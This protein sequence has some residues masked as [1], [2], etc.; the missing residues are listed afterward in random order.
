[1]YFLLKSEVESIDI[2]RNYLIKR[3]FCPFCRK[4]QLK[5]IDSNDLYNKYQCWNKNCDEKGAPFVVMNDYI[6]NEDLFD[7]TCNDCQER[8]HREFLIDDSQNLLLYFKCDGKLCETNLEPY[9]YNFSIGEWNGKSPKFVSYDDSL[10]ANDLIAKIV[11]KNTK[12]F[13]SFESE[14][15]DAFSQLQEDFQGHDK[16]L[17]THCIEDIPLLTMNNHEYSEFLMYHQNKVVVLVD[18]PNFIRTLRRLFPRQFNDILK[19]AHKMLIQYVQKSFHLTS[20]Y[21][22]RYFSKPD[23]DLQIPNKILMDFC[24]EYPEQEFFHLLKVPKRGGYSDIDNYLIAN[25]VEIL[26]RCDIK[27]FVIVSSDKDYLPVMRIASYKKVKSRILGI[28]TPEIY[29]KYEIEDVKF[30]GM[31]RFFEN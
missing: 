20:D 22:I 18:T 6:Q 17:Q 23:K 5:K 27:G 26:E 9:C 14:K 4:N 15:E 11:K 29:E 10:E 1:M 7:D 3:I 13:H 12:T 2:Q 21:I 30:L 24:I 31:M 19:N 8:L 28:N 25:G 16:E